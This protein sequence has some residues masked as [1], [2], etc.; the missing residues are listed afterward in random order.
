MIPMDVNEKNRQNDIDRF[1]LGKMSREESESFERSLASDPGLEAETQTTRRIISAVSRLASDKAMISGWEK[2]TE[3]KEVRKAVSR[4]RW[5][6]FGIP[7]AAVAVAAVMITGIYIYHYSKHEDSQYTAA[8]EQ[9]VFRGASEITEIYDLLDS[10][11]Y[12]K[13]LAAIDEALRDTIIDPTLPAEEKEYLYIVRDDMAY[14][15][16]W[17]RIRSLH[18]LGKDKEAADELNSFV[19]TDGT[20][21]QEAKSLLKN[22]LSDT[23]LSR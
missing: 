1:L 8:N 23:A 10:A 17:L 18:A 15:L 7:T 21:K 22:I 12:D 14:E 5:R 16:K 3:E 2:E 9:Y 6:R 11:R 13:A 20:H 4:R 19:N